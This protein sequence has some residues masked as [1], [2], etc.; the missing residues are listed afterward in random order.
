MKKILII[1]LLLLTV[2]SFAQQQT[3]EWIIPDSI[4]EEIIFNPDSLSG[5]FGIGLSNLILQPQYTE[6][7]Y[8]LMGNH[9]AQFFFAYEV[10]CY[11]DSIYMEY[12]TY[13]SSPSYT[14]D[15]G[16]IVVLG[17][18]MSPIFVK[19]WQHKK[20]TFK[21]FAQWLRKNFAPERTGYKI[22]VKGKEF[23]IDLSD[24]QWTEKQKKHVK[25]LKEMIE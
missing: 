7:E 22:H 23:K 21:G 18:Y 2:G 15:N 3:L 4:V 11:N 13:P 12:W 19:E 9:F 10:E 20:P 17:V 16:L 5:N 1:A 14:D 24:K 25:E 8:F 6:S